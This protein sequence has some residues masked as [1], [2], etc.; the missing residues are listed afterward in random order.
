M[1]IYTFQE[2]HNVSRILGLSAAEHRILVVISSGYAK[3]SSKIAKEANV[4]R[5]S[6]VY[7]LKNLEERGLVESCKS[8]TPY[9]GLRDTDYK[10]TV[11]KCD[12]CKIARRMQ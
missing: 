1:K 2:L 12:I 4:P 11:W 5:G 3:F 6:I 10:R 9:W 8:F 7:L